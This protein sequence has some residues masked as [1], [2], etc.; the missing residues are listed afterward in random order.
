MTQQGV[1]VREVAQTGT[2]SVLGV[3]CRTLVVLNAQDIGTRTAVAA[4]S[5]VAT[6]AVL[7][8]V[9]CWKMTLPM[10]VVARV[11]LWLRNDD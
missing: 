11:V 10:P 2:Q 1:D 5:T 6:V 7:W 4:V 9:P 8:A 3:V